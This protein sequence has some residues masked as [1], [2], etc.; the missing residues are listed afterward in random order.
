MP[1]TAEMTQ[2]ELLLYLP[3]NWLPNNAKIRN[4]N[5]NVVSFE[6]NFV[7]KVVLRTIVRLESEGKPIRIII[8]KAR[9]LGITTFFCGIC[10]YWCCCLKNR[11]ALISAH[12]DES[13]TMIFS[14]VKMMNDENPESPPTDHT[15]RKE[16]IYSPPHRS[17]LSVQTAGR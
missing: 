3:E 4:K 12:D 13:S 14:I 6:L 17:R 16:V 10:Y 15:T 1:E 9:K 2:E 7:Q 11:E 5:F 8:L